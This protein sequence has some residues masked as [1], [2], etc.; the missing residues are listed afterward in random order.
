M[1]KT[2]DSEDEKNPF[3]KDQLRKIEMQKKKMRDQYNSLD[4][5][6]EPEDYEKILKR[7]L[8]YTPK[9][10]ETYVS[11]AKKVEI[12]A[13]LIVKKNVQTH[14]NGPKG[15]WFTHR[16][17]SGCFACDDINLIETLV[18]T[19]LLIASRHPNQRF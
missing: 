18:D 7:D 19:M 8:D 1:D 2:F 5:P 14:I 17:P 15:A 6:V 12:Y 10:N 3:Y 13:K 11:Y 9:L 4:N 16:N